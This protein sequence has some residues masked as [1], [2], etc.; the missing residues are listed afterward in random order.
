MQPNRPKISVDQAP[1]RIEFSIR[2]DLMSI[3]KPAHWSPPLLCQVFDSTSFSLAT[4]SSWHHV[5]H[6]AGFI[7]SLTRKLPFG[8]RWFF[9]T[10]A[11]AFRQV[12]LHGHHQ[13]M[14]GQE[15]LAMGS[16]VIEDLA[17][18]VP[19]TYT[20][21]QRT[22]LWDTRTAIFYKQEQ[23]RWALQDR[24]SVCWT[25]FSVVCQ[26]K[27]RYNFRPGPSRTESN[28]RFAKPLYCLSNDVSVWVA[29]AFIK[30]N[31][32]KRTKINQY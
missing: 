15:V 28:I 5:S 32:K 26:P 16:P 11:G 19:R 27:F 2:F 22:L 25:K 17:E 29:P 30:S 18:I 23:Q 20:V 8:W 24:I 21:W 31:G 7:R 9:L 3:A 1:H 4:S 14:H 6:L 10:S 13:C 12:D